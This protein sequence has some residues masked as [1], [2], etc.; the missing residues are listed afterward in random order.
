MDW[1]MIGIAERIWTG[2]QEPVMFH[3]IKSLL[4]L[5]LMLLC[6]GINS[7]FTNQ[8]E[9]ISNCL[10][11]SK[12]DEKKSHINTRIYKNMCYFGRQALMV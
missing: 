8:G 11:L 6:N 12:T 5:L 7:V 3:V 4:L 2:L 1:L 10:D 9:Y